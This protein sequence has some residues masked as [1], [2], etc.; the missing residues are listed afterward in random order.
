M[1][2]SP[3]GF[4]TGAEP[5]TQLRSAHEVPDFGSSRLCRGSR[6]ADRF[7]STSRLSALQ[8]VALEKEAVR[9]VAT[10]IETRKS[11][12]QLCAER[13]ESA[14]NYIEKRRVQRSVRRAQ[15]QHCIALNALSGIFR[16]A[17]W[18]REECLFVVAGPS[19]SIQVCREILI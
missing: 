15:A 5:L 17:I 1:V 11:V 9:V 8:K 6:L 10:D 12:P 2:A 14:R 19:R 16:G 18:D 13:V 3:I 7:R 4:L